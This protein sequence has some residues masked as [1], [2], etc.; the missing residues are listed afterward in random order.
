MS[1]G[2]DAVAPCCWRPGGTRRG[3]V[4]TK[5]GPGGTKRGLG[6]WPATDAADEGDLEGP[7][8]TRRGLGGWS[9][10]DGDFRKCQCFLRHV[11]D[12]LLDY[13]AAEG[14]G[15]TPGEGKLEGIGEAR[16]PPADGGF[17]GD[18]RV[19]VASAIACTCLLMQAGSADRAAGDG[20]MYL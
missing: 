11:G 10:T 20:G 19:W 4:G 17:R 13:S 6:G 5:R 15:A 9:A 8:G 14:S 1:P 18:Q 7:G 3:P 2:G 16:S 12:L